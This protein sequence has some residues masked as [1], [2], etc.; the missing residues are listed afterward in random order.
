[1][2]ANLAKTVTSSLVLLATHRGYKQTSILFAEP[3]AMP[4][5]K[6]TNKKPKQSSG[7]TGSKGGSMDYDVG[8]PKPVRKPKKKK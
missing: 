4:N 7:K 3:T 1:M 5:K 2:T 8:S 6:S